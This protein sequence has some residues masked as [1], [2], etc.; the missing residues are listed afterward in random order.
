MN[1]VPRKTP[2][3]QMIDGVPRSP[4]L[5]PE[6]YRAASKFTP[7]AN[8][9]ILVTYPKSG[10]HWLSQIV[11]LVLNKGRSPRDLQDL[12]RQVPAIEYH[13]V[14][15][16]DR[17][18]RLLCTHLPFGQLK[19]DK[20]AKYIYVARNPWDICV[21][22]YHHVKQLPHYGFLDGTF[23]DFVEAFLKSKVGQLDHLDHVLSGYARRD[24]PNVLFLTY[25]EL[26]ADTAGAVLKLARFLG[27]PY[28]TM[29]DRDNGLMGAVLFKSSI[30]YM[31]RAHEVSREELDVIYNCSP[32]SEEVEAEM[33]NTRN[34]TTRICVVRKGTAGDGQS[35]F[36]SEL[37]EQMQAWIN[38]K[39]RDS[40]VMSIWGN[41]LTAKNVAQVARN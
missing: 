23:E 10:T 18:P 27:E 28:A 14:A 7:T 33:K 2:Y 6:V 17:S 38:D 19:Y 5:K 37:Q 41:E 20:N 3:L 9:V 30:D 39:T 26:R 29:F 16:S 21:S 32:I 34:G 12:A 11:V 40:D 13:G 1:K 35:N 15:A 24:E 31:R 36:S 8:D 4:L 22:F 25:E